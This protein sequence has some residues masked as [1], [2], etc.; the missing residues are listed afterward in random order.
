MAVK[1]PQ[2]DEECHILKGQVQQL[3]N[4]ATY[5]YLE[6]LPVSQEHGGT[7]RLRISVRK[8]GVFT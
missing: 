7:W 4:G 2:N 3:R 5:S 8:S 1:G 6:A